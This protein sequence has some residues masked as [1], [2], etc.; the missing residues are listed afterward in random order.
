MLG[1]PLNDGGRQIAL[2]RDLNEL[3]VPQPRQH[4]YVA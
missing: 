1:L 4:Q 3:V 2:V